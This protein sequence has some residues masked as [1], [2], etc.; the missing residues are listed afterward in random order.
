[1]G[2]RELARRSIPLL[3]TALILA[4]TRYAAWPGRSPNE[5]VWLV[6]AGLA[7]TLIA[8]F[9]VE[10]VELINRPKSLLYSRSPLRARSKLH[11]ATNAFR[12]P[13]VSLSPNPLSFTVLRTPPFL[14][15]FK[16]RLDTCLDLL[17]IFG[18]PWALDPQNE[19][20]N[21]CIK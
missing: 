14:S 19:L 3:T 8:N 21:Y 12:A 5:I 18:A 10:G 16:Q 2:A 13:H 6:R 7:G 9:A 17:P 11:L 15:I 1:M 20:I 4:A